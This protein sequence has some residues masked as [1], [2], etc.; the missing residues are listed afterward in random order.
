MALSTMPNGSNVSASRS[1]LK[2]GGKLPTKIFPLLLR[3][4]MESA[5]RGTPKVSDYSISARCDPAG[6]TVNPP[7]R[8]GTASLLCNKPLHTARVSRTDSKDEVHTPGGIART[9]RERHDPVLAGERG[10]RLIVP[11]RCRDWRKGSLH[12][13]ARPHQVF[14]DRRSPSVAPARRR[15]PRRLDDRQSRSL[16]HFA[17]NGAAGPA[18]ADRPGIAARCAE[19][20]V[21][22]IRDAGRCLAFLRPVPPARH[23]SDR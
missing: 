1:S 6:T 7:S 21:A 13:P 17:A 12:D 3:T 9:S 2:S 11:P 19:L 15:P 20:G 5:C 16:G 23:P 14:G 22:R 8:Y 18:G 4:H 10:R